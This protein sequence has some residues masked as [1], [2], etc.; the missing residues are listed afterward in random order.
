MLL[1][2]LIASQKWTLKSIDISTAFLRGSKQDSR[3]LGVEPPVEM[4][5]RLGLKEEE[6]CELLKGAY[7]LVNAPLLW[8]IELRNALLDLGFQV[9]PLDPCLFILPKE[10]TKGQ[11]EETCQIHGVLGVHVDDGICGGDEIF[12]QT[13]DR[14]EKKFPFG[15]KKSQKFTFT[16][17]Q[18]TQEAN[19][20]T[21]LNQSEYI[22]DIPPIEISRERRKD[23]KALANHQE[24]QA[25]RGLIGSL[26]YAA[27]NT[28]PDI[29]C[30]LSLLQARIP[31]ATIEDLL[32][33]DRLLDDAKRHAHVK[34]RIQSLE[35]EEVRFLSFSDA[36]FATRERAHSQR[37]TFILATTS[38]VED[39]R[40]TKVSPLI[41]SS[42][43]INRVVSSTLASETY[44][45]SGA[46]DQLSWVRLMWSWLL[47][48]K[49]DWRK[50]SETL[51][52]LPTA[53]AVVDCKSLYDL[54]Q[55]TAV[56]SCSEYRTLLGALVIKDRLK[57]GIV[58]KWVWPMH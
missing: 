5:R 25:L 3:I 20:D 4:R 41:W 38:K 12:N 21:Q 50:P 36:A 55:K 29:S 23:Q 31:T 6:A 30:R 15:S 48:P 34:I 26:Q 14:L 8:Y 45:L 27:T 17:V 44:A 32:I 57:E 18:L 7:G 37:G 56:P 22:R 33:A 47:N 46:L 35:P 16:G 39:E 51:T 13:I 54:L 24:I 2:Q 43:K 28:R 52:Q 11:P 19:G 10:K 9:S 1:L 40:G 49:I 53:F 58:I 42:R